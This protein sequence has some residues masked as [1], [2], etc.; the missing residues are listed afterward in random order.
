MFYDLRMI[1]RVKGTSRDFTGVGSGDEEQTGLQIVFV[2]PKFFFF[3]WCR[4]FLE[5]LFNLFQYCFFIM[6]CF[7]GYEACRILAP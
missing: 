5:S 2:F 4:L 1:Q 3:F 7:S 6:V